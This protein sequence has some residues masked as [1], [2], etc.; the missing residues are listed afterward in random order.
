MELN[1]FDNFSVHYLRPQ[2]TE[3]DEPEINKISEE[4]QDN[5]ESIIRNDTRNSR[6]NQITDMIQEF[7]THLIWKSKNGT[8]MHYNPLYFL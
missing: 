7:D 1:V 3:S 5:N 6:W 4:F 8:W 2:S